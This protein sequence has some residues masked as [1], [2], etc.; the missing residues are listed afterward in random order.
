MLTVSQYLRADPYLKGETKFRRDFVFWVLVLAAVL[1]G[2]LLTFPEVDLAIAAAF[3]DMCDGRVETRGW[4][5]G[6]ITEIVRHA[7]MAIFVFTAIA[8]VAATVRTCYT[9]GSL[10]GLEQARCWFLLLAFVAG[11]GLVANLAFKDNWGRARPREIVEFGGAKQF[12]APLVPANE[13]ARNCAFVS[14]EASSVFVTFFALSLLIPQY[15]VALIAGGIA[16]GA[17]AGLIRMSQGAHFMSDIV[18]AGIFMALTVSVVHI[19]TIDIWK[20][21][22]RGGAGGGIPDAFSRARR[23]V[24]SIPA[25]L[26]SSPRLP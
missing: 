22:G 26:G 21:T 13:C 1:A 17:V 5:G 15:R 6:T 9:R 23:I 14:G 10:F 20:E 25:F 24:W 3:R 2:A 8:A 16:T 12:T 7:F 18:F 11:P 4:C 19:L